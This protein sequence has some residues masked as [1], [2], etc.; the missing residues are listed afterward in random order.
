METGKGCLLG[1]GYVKVSVSSERT[2]RAGSAGS[3]LMTVESPG[4]RQALGLLLPFSF[5]SAAAECRAGGV[6]LVPKNLIFICLS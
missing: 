2:R 6:A 3:T 4:G 1:V 5:A